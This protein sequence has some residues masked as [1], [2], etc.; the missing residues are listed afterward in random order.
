MGAADLA[1]FGANRVV[2]CGLL[3]VTVV[4]FIF[5]FKGGLWAVTGGEA[6]LSRVET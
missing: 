6:A 2:S 3:S 5:P 1:G 4:V